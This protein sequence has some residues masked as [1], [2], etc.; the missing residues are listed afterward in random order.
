MCQIHKNHIWVSGQAFTYLF[1][2]CI[3]ILRYLEFVD[4]SLYP[5]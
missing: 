5:N 1:L 2:S 3:D 4:D